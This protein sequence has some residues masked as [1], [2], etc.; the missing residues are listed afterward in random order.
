M[1]P[2]KKTPVEIIE[3]EAQAPAPAEAPQEIKEAQPINP[4]EDKSEQPPTQ[5]QQAQTPAPIE[6]SKGGFVVPKNN[7]ELLRHAAAMKR[8]G[9]VPERF[10]TEYE[11]YAAVC[12]VRSLGL[13]DVAI[14]QT[15][16]IH[17]TP[18]IFGDLPLALVQRTGQL[19]FFR[20]Y[21]IDKEYN[22]IRVSN[23]NLKAPIF[24]TVCEIEREGYPREEFVYTIDDAIAAGQIKDIAKLKGDDVWKY[25]KTPWHKHLKKMMRYKAR[26]LA[27]QS[28]FADALNGVSI[29]EDWGAYEEGKGNIKD[30]TPN[31]FEKNDPA[32]EL[33]SI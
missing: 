23:K 8:G 3:P 14:R 24:A 16:V 31:G 33:N 12:Y 22:E 2:R 28:Q 18:S 13:P 29:G 9:M 26:I 30:V 7:Q 32:S 27:L 21:M 6:L 11:V 17:G 15:A 5:Q 1:S 25:E 20:E 19:K 4:P 10:K